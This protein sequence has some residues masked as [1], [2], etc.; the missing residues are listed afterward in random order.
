MA[1]VSNAIE[2]RSWRIT[3]RGTK[4]V[5]VSSLRS[6]LNRG[7]LFITIFDA[8]DFKICKD[9]QNFKIENSLTRQLK[10]VLV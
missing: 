2:R 7:I 9:F 8:L 5:S 10:L 6:H 1:L 3:A 4:I